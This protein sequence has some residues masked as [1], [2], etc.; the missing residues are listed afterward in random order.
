MAG[1]SSGIT[2]VT[3]GSQRGQFGTSESTDQ[4]ALG[5]AA[6]TTEDSYVGMRGLTFEF[7]RL[8]KRAKPAVA[9]RVQRRVRRHSTRK[10]DLAPDYRG[11]DFH[12]LRLVP[13]AGNTQERCRRHLPTKV[14][15]HRAPCS[16]KVGLF[17]DDVDNEATNI[18]CD[19]AV[20][21]QDLA[22]ICQA[23]RCLSARVSWRHDRT[24]GGLWHLACNEE[25]ISHAPRIPIVRCVGQAC[26]GFSFVHAGAEYVWILSLLRDA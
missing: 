11:V 12:D 14:L 23:L 2:L 15:S 1:P 21:S 9:G 18:Q 20:N 19:E 6:M 25:L 8:R 7:T 26:G 3:V 24:I 4:T 17:P 22:Q 16:R 13:Q 10:L 5:A